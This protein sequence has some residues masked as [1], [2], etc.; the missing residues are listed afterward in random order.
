MT[1]SLY[2]EFGIWRRPNIWITGNLKLTSC[3]ILASSPGSPGTRI[4]IAQLQFRVPERGSLGTRLASYSQLA[5]SL[6]SRPPSIGS[7]NRC[8]GTGPA[9]LKSRPLSIG[10]CNGC[11]GTGPASLKSRPPPAAEAR[12]G[13]AVGT[14]ILYN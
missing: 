13:F 14:I 1:S 3:F 12:P 4:Y 2:R 7:Y 8:N 6:E 11:N 5:Y 9:S 10:P